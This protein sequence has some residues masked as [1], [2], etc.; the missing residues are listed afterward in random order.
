MNLDLG[1]SILVGEAESD[2]LAAQAVGCSPVQVLTGRN[3][4]QVDRLRQAEAN[5]ILVVGDLRS[6]VGWIASRTAASH[7][8]QESMPVESTTGPVGRCPF[9]GMAPPPG[10]STVGG[11][12]APAA[13]AQAMR[14]AQR[15]GADNGAAGR[16]PD[17]RRLL[18]ATSVPGLRWLASGS[19]PPNPADVLGSAR[20]RERLAPMK[21][22]A[23]MVLVDSAPAIVPSDA[24]VL[25]AQTGG[26]LSVIDAPC[27]RPNRRGPDEPG[28]DA[29]R[30][31]LARPL[32]P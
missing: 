4:G 8:R 18:R 32:L 21:A 23:D 2:A 14:T 27:K 30:R 16:R 26:V 28:A 13:A 17:I 11:R 20:M 31:L 3:A 22:G 19:V 24:A 7:T 9:R 6:A 29:G 25:A 12:P 15:R 5:A 10:Q 1:A